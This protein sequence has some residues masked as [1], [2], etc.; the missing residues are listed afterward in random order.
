M[1]QVHMPKVKGQGHRRKTRAQQL[2]TLAENQV[3][4]ETVDK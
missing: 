2:L 3:E 1:G 4:L